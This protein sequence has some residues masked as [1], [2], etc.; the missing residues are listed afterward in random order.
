MTPPYV[1][2]RASISQSQRLV[3]AIAG[4]VLV[5]A[6]LSRLPLLLESFRGGD[7]PPDAG[8]V[9]AL[10]SSVIFAIQIFRGRWLLASICFLALFL[11]LEVWATLQVP[12]ATIEGRPFRYPVFLQRLPFMLV[13]LVSLVCVI[14]ARYALI[15]K[16]R[17][18]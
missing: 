2:T 9:I 15:P 1:E 14:F 10:V 13:H 4:V 5:L 6:E 3:L 12:I 18:S 17:N 16:T 11:A 7:I 8:G